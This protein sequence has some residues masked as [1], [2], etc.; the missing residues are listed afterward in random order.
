METDAG[1]V[2]AEPPEAESGNTSFNINIS[3]EMEG[4]PRAATARDDGGNPVTGS[5]YREVSMVPEI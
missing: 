3:V 4:S 1:S 2:V 5:G